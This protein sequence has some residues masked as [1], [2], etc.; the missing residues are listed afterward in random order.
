[1]IA[2]IYA[3]KSNDDERTNEDGR[4]IDRQVELARAFALSRGGWAVTE[5]FSDDGISG[6]EF[7]NRPGFTR[8]VEAAKHRPRPFDAVILMA[9]NRLGRDQVNVMN[10]LT[11]L[12]DAGVKVFPYQTGNEVKLETPTEILVA[13]VEAFADAAY[14]HTIKVNT[15]EALQRKAKLGHNCGQKTF[16]YAVVRLGPQAVLSRRAGYPRGAGED[17]QAG[18][19]AGRRRAWQPA[20]RDHAQGRGCPSPRLEVVEV[21]RP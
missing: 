12:R 13:S 20:D 4:S 9:L 7:V 16:G 18:V 5:V 21:R 1:M 6:A 3:R 17:Y 14:R 2:A 8:M 11:A 19:R 15:R 10:A